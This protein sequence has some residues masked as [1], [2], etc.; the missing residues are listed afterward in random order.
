MQSVSCGGV[1]SAKTEMLFIIMKYREF[2]SYLRGEEAGE[3][4]KQND[5]TLKSKLVEMDKGLSEDKESW[6]LISDYFRISGAAIY[7]LTHLLNWPVKS[8]RYS[9][10]YLPLQVAFYWLLQVNSRRKEAVI[11]QVWV[12]AE[13][14]IKKQPLSYTIE[15]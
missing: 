8:T 4:A 12:N 3:K 5:E 11:S 7:A 2:L 13:S 9:C 14:D 15:K 10:I 6:Y 1:I